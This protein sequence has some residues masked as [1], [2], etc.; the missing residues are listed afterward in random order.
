VSHAAVAID[1]DMESSTLTHWQPQRSSVSAEAWFHPR[2]VAASRPLVVPVDGAV[3]GEHRLRARIPVGVVVQG[4]DGIFTAENQ[5]LQI[6]ATGEDPAA[7][8]AEFRSQLFE[9]HSHYL[10]LRDDEVIGDARALRRLFVES[11]ELR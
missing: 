11:F 1:Y 7:A 5:K 10:G 4:S 6:Y 8:L 2:L 9:L 3:R